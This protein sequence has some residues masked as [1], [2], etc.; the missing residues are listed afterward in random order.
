MACRPSPL[1]SQNE[2]LGLSKY[3][4]YHQGGAYD[5]TPYFLRSAMTT[6]VACEFGFLSGIIDPEK[7]ENS[8]RGLS[9]EKFLATEV[10]NRTAAIDPKAVETGLLDALRLREYWQG[11]FTALTPPADHRGAVIAYQL[12]LADE[13][14]GVAVVLRREEAP[15]EFSLKLSDLKADS[16]YELLLSDEALKETRALASGELLTKGFP[17]YLTSAP[18]SLAVFYRERSE[19]I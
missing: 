15:E 14:R 19:C 1:A 9:A 10:K 12:H 13:G 18:S 2:I 5:Y 8:I 7:E 4:P 3:I 11:D 16:E 6:G 17:V